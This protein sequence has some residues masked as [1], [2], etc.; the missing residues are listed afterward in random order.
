VHGTRRIEPLLSATNSVLNASEY[1]VLI[2]IFDDWESARA[3]IVQ[4]E[5]VFAGMGCTA[6]VLLVDDGSHSAPADYATLA[7]AAIRRVDTLRM[8]RNLGHQRAICIGLC[9]VQASP[10]YASCRG[11]VIMDG[12]G[13]D[14]PA[15]VPRLIGRFRELEEERVVFAERRR[16]SEGVVF[17]ALYHLYR[18]AHRAAT[19]ISVRVGN[20]SVVPMPL[21][22]RLAVVSE[23]W[24]HY[25]AAVLHARL[26][27]DMV[28]TVRGT[29]LHGRSRMNFI[30]LVGHGLSAMSVF[31]DRIGVRSLV[32]TMVMMLILFLAFVATI[33]IRLLTTIAI[34]GW[35]SIALGLIGVLLMQGV[36]LSAVFTFLIQ[37]GRAGSSFL[38][39]RDYAW[40]IEG[41]TP[42]RVAD[43]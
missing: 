37:L 36:L 25:A 32:V 3:L 12:D 2:P 26:P 28:P 23:M 15:D 10:D 16:R 20:F 7:L 39:A 14:Q 38:P 27:V 9:H 21:A 5:G 24:N 22:R 6:R 8:R 41:E 43:A 42:L 19:G 18:G 13:E 34:P 33:A 31:S 30:S 17:T 29:R 11:I 35:A 1:V 40:F 4:L